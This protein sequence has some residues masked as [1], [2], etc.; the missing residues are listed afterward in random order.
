MV[1]Q[2]LLKTGSLDNAIREFH[3]LS[4]H[5]L[6]AIIPCSTNMASVSVIFGAFY[7]LFSFVCYIMGSASLSS[8]APIR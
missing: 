2:Q 6:R 5:W 8:C 7:F 1:Y 3:W 4:H